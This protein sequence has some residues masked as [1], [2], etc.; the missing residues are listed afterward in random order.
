MPA[1]AS[2]VTLGIAVMSAQSPNAKALQQL[3]DAADAV[4]NGF[5]HSTWQC[6]AGPGPKTL[7]LGDHGVFSE[8]KLEPGQTVH[9]HCDLQVADSVGGVPLLGEAL[10]ATVN[11][12]YPVDLWVNGQSV[13]KDDGVPVAAGPAL[14]AQVVL[15]YYTLR[16][17]SG[18][19]RPK[20]YVDGI[21]S[22]LKG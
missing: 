10:E 11:S 1:A 16:L 15:G 4:A 8:L 7:T 22:M 19:V 9:L 6:L 12:L 5:P 20:P 21:V 18:D 14:F 17:T 2:L 3:R 13:F